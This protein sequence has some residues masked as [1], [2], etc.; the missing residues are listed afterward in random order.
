M[1]IEKEIREIQK[2]R[3]DHLGSLIF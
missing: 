1:V 2:V 3:L